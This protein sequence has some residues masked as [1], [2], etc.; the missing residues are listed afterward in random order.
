MPNKKPEGGSW[1]AGGGKGGSGGGRGASPRPK[2]FMDKSPRFTRHPSGN[3][4]ERSTGDVY[5]AAGK[6][7][8]PK[9]M[10][11]PTTAKK[12]VTVAKKVAN[13]RAASDAKKVAKVAVPVGIGAAALKKANDANKADMKRLEQLRKQY[14]K[15]AAR[16]SMTFNEYV[17]KYG[18]K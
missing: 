2:N 16:N 11:K 17:K 12:A 13:S 5:T 14:E 9:P 1:K 18:N 6:L 8:K 4:I 3:Y 15:S 10:P 7:V